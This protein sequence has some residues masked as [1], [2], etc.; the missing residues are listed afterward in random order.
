MEYIFDNTICVFEGGR[1]KV[2]KLL[3]AGFKEEA[4]IL[5]VTICEV[6]LHDFCKTCKG[7]WI[8]QQEGKTV[9]GAGI[10]ITSKYKI[11]IRNYLTSI[12][13]Y[14]NFLKSY[15]V[16]EYT[17][18]DPDIDAIYDVLF[19]KNE[20]INFQNLNDT[21]GANKAYEF[22]FNIDLKE[23]LDSNKE[24]SLIKWKQLSQLIQERHKIIHNGAEGEM[25]PSEIKDVLA[26]LDYL[27][28]FLITK[29][30]SYYSVKN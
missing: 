4:I 8:H 30:G 14:E 13:A 10:P 11:K 9:R 21:K 17:A 29:I 24:I 15:Y 19:E 12:G 26:S 1:D 25:T 27:K 18:M 28:G 23:N 3:D 6:L 7:V 22:F 20:R 2:V 16:F 5:T